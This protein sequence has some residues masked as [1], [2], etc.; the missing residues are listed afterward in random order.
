MDTSGD[1]PIGL[2][3]T[4]LTDGLK[5]QLGSIVHQIHEYDAVDDADL[6]H[7]LAQHLSALALKRLSAIKDPV[8]RITLANAVLQ[9][10]DELPDPVTTPARQLHA[11]RLP[12][13]PGTDGRL[14]KRP[15]T[16]L[17]DAA[18]LTNA[19]GE[20]SLA[21]E[22]RAEIDSADSID[23]LCAFVMWHGLRLIEGELAAARQAGIPIRVVTTTYIGGTERRALDRLVQ[24]FGA[25]VKVQYDAKR[26]RLHAKA[27]LFDRHTGYDTA[28]VGSSN[29]TTS[30]ML[31]GVEWNVRLS[32]AAT[33][34]L[35]DKFRATFDA[36]W[37]SPEFESYD[38]ERDRDR[39]DDALLEAKGAKSSGRVTISLVGL[40]VRPYPYQQ[41]MLDELEAE[42][43][44]HDR[45]RNLV[46]AATGTGKTVIAALDY[47]RMCQQA[48]GHQP[49]LLFVAHRKEILE[50]SI[51]T[52]REV[53]GDASF[54]ELYVGGQRPERW[55]HVFASVQSLTSYGVTE[56]P[57]DA[58][59]V[60]VIDEFHH[61]EAR[62]YRSVIEHLRPAEL[63][64]LTATPERADGTDVR[65]FF[66]GRTATE[67]RLWDALG[68]DLLCPFHYF[69]IADGTDLRAITWT[70]GRY[71]ERELE[72][73]FTGND[74]RAR[75]I[76]KQLQEK[77]ADPHRMRA[78]GFCVSV[79]HATYMTRVFT[80]AGIPAR[81]VTGQSTADDRAA[82][83]RDLRA[84]TVNVLF[85][86]DVFNEGLDIPDVDTVL[87][88]RPTESSTIFMQQLGR[89]LRRTHN[90]AV[91]TVLDFVGYHRREFSFAKKFAAL[92][93]VHGKQL[94]KAVQDEFPFLPSGCQIQLDRQ[95]QEIVLDNLRT[96]VSPRWAHL[97]SAL[98]QVGDT[99]LPTFLERSGVELS[100]ISRRGSWTA[101]RR[102]AGFDSLPGSELEE[103]LLKRVRAFAHVDDPER[104]AAY[105][106]LLHQDAPKYDE[107]SEGEQR[108]ARMLFYSF[109]SDG[110][111]F[112]SYGDGLESIR[113]ESAARAEI[114]AVV[115]ISYEAT[116]HVPLSLDGPLSPVPL[117]VHARYQREEILAA[118][119]FPRR[120]NSFREGVL[121][122]PNHNVD[123]FF[124]TLKKS[125]ADYSP[126]TM[127]ADYPISRDLFH[128]ESQST[129]STSSKT[130]Q[131][132]LTGT[133]TVLMFV[134]HEAKDDFGT[135]P[136]T[137]M[138]PA[139]YVSH[140][141]ER[142][143]AITWKL[144]HPMPME[145]FQHASA[146]AQ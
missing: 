42:R 101:L 115:D 77:V 83:L 79:A 44:V 27:W 3:E 84:A 72:G 57:A 128:W 97:V 11:L 30:A 132:Y 36:Y 129:T 96:Q 4:L 74:A 146:I 9:A 39:L 2:H 144:E 139:R 105:D 113:R 15:K 136:Y 103:R 86:V 99:D 53:L 49:R 130:G 85:T 40:D 137:F 17:N 102:D 6:P 68:A 126:T 28:Y 143:I 131:R 41:Q 108:L 55:S 61:A 141:G 73:V 104:A 43:V 118:L 109:W 134:R 12:D 75:I 110:G 127:Y 138:G 133:S 69:A 32:A 140:S 117:K 114:R 5:E 21:S 82:A 119:D 25:E 24:D 98:R 121:Y 63:L 125:E 54:G 51:R 67:L 76:L 46:V 78:L 71:D 100:D 22:L 52:Y 89:G 58:Y 123:A 26:T 81:L 34:A 10:I 29:L 91:L 60:V 13:G 80:E 135:S 112:D 87:F 19:P 70:R 38:P 20:P 56:I 124:V 122:L 18:L 50:Q 92:T 65:S 7:V 16:P 14:R 62:T 116:R 37:N 23:L 8:A 142:P 59:D 66:D 95:A 64:G 120:P 45:H 31:E 90:K 107:L 145:F 33:P 48:G 88:L 35:L 93:G 106:A 111:G 1:L 94:Q 47:R